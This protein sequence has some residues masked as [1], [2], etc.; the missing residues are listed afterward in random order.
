MSDF[1]AMEQVV[2][3]ATLRSAGVLDSRTDFG[4]AL[5]LE[6]ATKKDA[7]KSSRTGPLLRDAAK[8]KF[9]LVER[10]IFL[11]AKLSGNGRWI[12]F[13]NNSISP[14]GAQNVTY[15]DFCEKK[16]ASTSAKDNGEAFHADVR[17]MAVTAMQTVTYANGQ[18]VLRAVKAK[19]TD[20]T[21]EELEANILFLMIGQKMRCK[22]TGTDF[23]LGKSNKY[24]KPSL[25]RIDS[26][27]GYVKGNLQILT[28]LANFTKSASD[29]DDWEEKVLAMCAMVDAMRG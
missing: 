29:A 28:R 22:L 3:S 4:K 17:R 10:G 24:L 19:D 14:E 25:D 16:S 8:A 15:R 26:S 11:P 21:S 23:A 20:M 12:L 2:I 1:K 18:S 27:R 13:F 5:I 6:E 7:L 9:E